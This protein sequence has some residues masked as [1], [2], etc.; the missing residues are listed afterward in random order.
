LKN[1]FSSGDT[2]FGVLL[3]A[4][5]QVLIVLA[6]TFEMNHQFFKVGFEFEVGLLDLL[7]VMLIHLRLPIALLRFFSKIGAFEILRSECV[8]QIST[9]ELGS[10]KFLLLLDDILLERLGKSLESEGGF[11]KSISFCFFF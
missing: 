11:G 3:D 7:V 8:F 9:I 4:S 1:L 6:Q 10:R 2:S 5:V